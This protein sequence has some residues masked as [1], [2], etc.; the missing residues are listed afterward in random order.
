MIKIII[1]GDDADSPAE[2]NQVLGKIPAENIEEITFEYQ[3]NKEPSHGYMLK[4]VPKEKLMK[5]INIYLEGHEK[6]K[7][8]YIQIKRM[9]K[10]E[11]IFLKHVRYFVSDRRKI[12][13][14]FDSCQD[15]VEFYMKMNDVEELLKNAGFL[16]CHQS[17]LV[18]IRH[19][20]YWDG[21]NIV[22][23]E[24]ERIPVSRKYKREIA[25]RF[26][27]FADEIL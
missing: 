23:T 13:A 16:R 9:E 18:N 2:L 8:Q 14:V 1:C 12:K 10:N 21:N 20:L 26:D 24:N 11:R 17:Y 27:E 4:S 22:L 15:T 5:M 6:K 7:I 19:I 25:C 3:G